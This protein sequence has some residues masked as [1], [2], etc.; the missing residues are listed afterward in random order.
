MATTTTDLGDAKFVVNAYGR[1]AG[2]IAP[3]FKVLVDGHVIGQASAATTT[4][5]AYT[6]HANV[7]LNQ[8]HK[9]MVQYDND[10]IVGGVDR[11]LF[12]KSIV[13]NGHVA[14]ATDGNVHFDRGALDGVD[15]LAGRERMSWN[16]TL[17]V[18]AP[19]V[20][21][22]GVSAALPGLSVGNA[23][24][25]EPTGSTS[26]SGIA[27]GYLHTAGN[28]IVDSS[29]HDVKLTGVNWF[30][31]EGYAF[32]PGGLWVDSYQHHMDK[33]SGLGFNVIRL[34]WSDAMLDAG[35]HPTGIDY[36]KNPDLQ[37]LTSLQVFDKI[38]DYAGK[39]G[40]RVILDHHRSGDG[41][42][43]NEN[44]LWYTDAYPESKMIADWKM[45]AQRYAGNPTVVGA[46]LH[47]EPHGAATW[48]TGSAA[49]D[50]AAGAERV[51]DA[52]QTV[53]KDWLLM[54][55]GVEVYN[56]TWDWWGGNLQGAKTRE[57]HF[58]TP[59]KL[60]YSVH[61]YGPGLFQQSWFN[62]SDF[63]NNLPA[64][65]TDVWGHLIK[66]D[67]APVLVGEFGGRLET[68]Q[69]KAWMAKL[70]QYMNGD[71]DGNGT[72][73]LG[74]GKQGA[75]WTYWAWNPTSGDTGGILKDDWT[76]VDTNK[77]NQIKA[78][79][80]SGSSS[81]PAQADASFTIKLSAASTDTVTVK[82]NTV[83][84]TAKAGHDYTAASGQLTFNPGE[85]SKVVK[86]HVLSDSTAEGN[87]SFALHLASAVKAS[88]DHADG[89]GTI[90]P[91][92]S[93]AAASLDVSVAA[94]HDPVIDHVIDPLHPL[95]HDMAA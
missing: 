63:P 24:L 90:T 10:A 31:A 56:N 4:A 23:S 5:H 49:T 73:D 54:V 35:R 28:Q 78:G 59:D 68:S 72:L 71:L 92:V 32:A 46:D 29:G 2:G 65:L 80:Y 16:G 67:V 25:A 50:W 11:N 40:M 17:I 21:F 64:K 58:D 36:S 14:A 88:I 15:M 44:G 47:N 81:V 12:V 83:D 84:G 22:P 57:I 82:Y 13:T 51:G 34:P 8:P 53:N 69:E 66:N 70:I 85:M 48:G 95:L 41:A 93:V 39:I 87:E 91:P 27:P 52:I 55:E 38:I 19:K 26:H 20:D 60:V 62:T 45:L 74:A 86:V 79:L 1:S 3:H 9:V 43:A 18:D 89:T 6:F 7:G 75:S 94:L 37:G 77:F 61:S 76:T 33:M 30:G 42:S